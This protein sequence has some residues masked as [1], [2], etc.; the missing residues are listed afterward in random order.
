MAVL[1]LAEIVSGEI[2][3]DQTGKALTAVQKLGEVLS[4]IHI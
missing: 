4:L 2:S 1:L 3:L